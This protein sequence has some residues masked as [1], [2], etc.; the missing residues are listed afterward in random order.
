MERFVSLAM[1]LM[2]VC[3]VVVLIRVLTLGTPDPSLPDQN[4]MNGL[5]YKWNRAAFVGR[6]ERCPLQGE[7]ELT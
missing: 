2:A 6:I 4:V 7:N 5:A 1:P 3:A